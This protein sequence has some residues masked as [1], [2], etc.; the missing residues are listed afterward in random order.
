MDNLLYDFTRLFSLPL[1][2][3]D[4]PKDAIKK[5]VAEIKKEKGEEINPEHCRLRRRFMNRIAKLY[6]NGSNLKGLNEKFDLVLEVC[7]EPPPE[8]NFRE[9][10]I[11]V[12]FW[13][14]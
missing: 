12:R 3:K 7:D 14:A 13:D 11:Y 1:S 5:I 4:H 2:K 10:L 6:R 9:I 8:V